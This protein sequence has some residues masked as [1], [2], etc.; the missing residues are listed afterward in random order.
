MLK[1]Q[2]TLFRQEWLSSI[3]W[4]S[5]TH[6]KTKLLREGS[7]AE[8]SHHFKICN[9]RKYMT[10]ASDEALNLLERTEDVEEFVDKAVED[11]RDI[12]KSCS[13]TMNVQQIDCDTFNVSVCGEEA[14][15]ISRGSPFGMTGADV[16]GTC[17]LIYPMDLCRNFDPCKPLANEISKSMRRRGRH[18]V[19]VERRVVHP[20]ER[21]FFE[22]CGRHECIEYTCSLFVWCDVEPTTEVYTMRYNICVDFS[23]SSDAEKSDRLKKRKKV[24]R[25]E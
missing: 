6:I 23:V 5:V 24:D 14:V 9:G 1:S 21:I 22:V 18:R 25:V 17:M 3:F 20:T 7:M 8:V 16:F 10:N 19:C 15:T 2:N 12:C 4:D 11:F 13:S